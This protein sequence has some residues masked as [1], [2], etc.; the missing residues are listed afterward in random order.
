MEGFTNL[1]VVFAQGPY[2]CILQI[3]VHVLPERRPFPTCLCGEPTARILVQLGTRKQTCIPA[4][5]RRGDKNRPD[6]P[7]L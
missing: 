3:L 4:G 6:E 1:R 2:L 5:G 7:S